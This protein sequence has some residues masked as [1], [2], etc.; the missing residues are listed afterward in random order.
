MVSKN[1]RWLIFVLTGGIKTRNVW[2]SLVAIYYPMTTH[3][4]A[5]G[6]FHMATNNTGQ[7]RPNS[8]A[9]LREPGCLW[10]M[11]MAMVKDGSLN[12]SWRGDGSWLLVMVM[13][14]DSWWWIMMIEDS[15]K[16][17]ITLGHG[18]CGSQF[19]IVVGGDRW[20]VVVHDDEW[21]L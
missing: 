2:H 20:M 10:S 16:W 1:G 11:V 12:D 14:G 17:W 4:L 3:G 21:C 9:V 7:P 5:N 15:Q 13:V 8:L 6:W 19:L 18:W